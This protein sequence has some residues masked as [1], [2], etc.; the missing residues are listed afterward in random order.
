M[1]A[2]YP[3]V[4]ASLS[5]LR[6]GEL[7][8]VGF[9]AASSGPATPRVTISTTGDAIPVASLLDALAGQTADQLAKTEPISQ[10]SHAP[11]T[12]P[13]GPAAELRY[14][15]KAQGTGADLAVDAWFVATAGRTFVL[16]FTVP[17]STAD[18]LRPQL[19][20]TAESLA[21]G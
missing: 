1:A 8:F 12:L 2:R 7:G 20:A 3:D 18:A 11:V 15:M 10:V 19:Q 21:G 13:A 9:D 6:T 17:V 4:A 16:T 14:H 5:R